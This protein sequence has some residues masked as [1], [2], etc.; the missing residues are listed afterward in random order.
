[1]ENSQRTAEMTRAVERNNHLLEQQLRLG[2]L[3][4]ESLDPE[5]AGDWRKDFEEAEA[6]WKEKGEV[7]RASGKVGTEANE[8]YRLM[9]GVTGEG[10]WWSQ[11]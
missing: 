9:D 7:P 6:D 1:M 8:W 4:L 10:G 11:G 5:R 3:L 2:V